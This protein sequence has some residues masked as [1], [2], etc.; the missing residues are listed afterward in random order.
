MI[1]RYKDEAMDKIWSDWAKYKRWLMVSGLGI[2]GLKD[3][4]AERGMDEQTVRCHQAIQS[5]AAIDGSFKPTHAIEIRGIEQTTRHDVAAFLEW[6]EGKLGL[7]LSSVLHIGM[8]SSDL[9]DSGLALGIH[10]SN[11]R[12]DKLAE[13][14]LVRM[15]NLE[16]QFGNKPFLFRTHGKDAVAGHFDHFISPH[17]ALIN[18]IIKEMRRATGSN[19]R[20]KLSG[21]VGIED[22]L[23]VCRHRCAQQLGHVAHTS[24]T[25]IVNRLVLLAPVRPIVSLACALESLATDLRLL[26]ISGV[27]EF[28]EGKKSKQIGSSAM[29]HKTNPIG[30]ENT[31]GLARV[32]R[33]NWG[34]LQES[35]NS[36]LSR[37]LSHSSVERIA[38]VDIYHA[39]AHMLKTMTRVLEEGSF[40]WGRIEQNIKAA[41][42]DIWSAEL[43]NYACFNC[44]KS[45]TEGRAIVERTLKAYDPERSG[46]IDGLKLEI[47]IACGRVF[48]SD[49]KRGQVT[50]E[51][52]PLF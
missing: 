51:T 49:S 37:D 9:V 34:A 5:L 36:W 43:L 11:A 14:L 17:F 45:R 15:A 47:D 50:E 30:C 6:L 8:T 16:V 32:V 12:I 41:T 48:V 26:S 28:S 22:D 35:A 27:N 29:P 39:V 33:H 20:V 52:N 42:P 4:A 31:C 1:D 38:L 24:T 40:G 25:Q 10:D 2:A 44:G 7:E 18:G 19:T 3:Y 21:A 23:F 46:G 13:D